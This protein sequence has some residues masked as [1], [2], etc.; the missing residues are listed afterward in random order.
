MGVFAG[1]VVQDFRRAGRIGIY[2]P[3][4]RR[5]LAKHGPLLDFEEI[6]KSGSAMDVLATY[7]DLTLGSLVDI[8]QSNGKG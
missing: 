3:S 1:S 7:K 8:L 4:A 5:H 6:I 2:V